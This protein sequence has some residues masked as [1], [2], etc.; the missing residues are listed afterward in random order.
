MRLPPQIAAMMREK[1]PDDLPAFV[2]ISSVDGIDID[3]SIEDSVAFAAEF[4]R[5][6]VDVIDCRFTDN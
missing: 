2:R 1:R 3:W 4:K 6:G 5:L